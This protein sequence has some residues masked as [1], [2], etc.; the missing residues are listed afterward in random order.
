MAQYKH[1]SLLNIGPFVQARV[2]KTLKSGSKSMPGW[3]TESVDWAELDSLE[4]LASSGGP[5]SRVAAGLQDLTG[6]D[7]LAT[8][9]GMT[10]AI[11][12]PDA[13]D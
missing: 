10:S 7:A 1:H 6:Y 4:G 8:K 13:P 9:A 11:A 5:V 3:G 12:V 2:A